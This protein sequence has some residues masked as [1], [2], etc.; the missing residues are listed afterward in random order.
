MGY[1]NSPKAGPIR[2]WPSGRER[3]TKDG[4]FAAKADIEVPWPLNTTFSQFHSL[5]LSYLYLTLPYLT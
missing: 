1:E 2:S 4:G 5:N 3:A